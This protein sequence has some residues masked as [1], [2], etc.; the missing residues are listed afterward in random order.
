MFVLLPVGYNIG[1]DHYLY[2]VA[3][4]SHSRENERCNE[5]YQHNVII[6]LVVVIIIIPVVRR[7]S[8]DT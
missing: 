5:S 7:T 2:G 1:G 8:F 3:R 4:Q 6:F